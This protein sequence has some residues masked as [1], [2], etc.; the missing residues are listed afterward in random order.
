M[1]VFSLESL[2][3]SI[4]K[5]GFSQK[6]E[7]FYAFLIPKAFSFNKGGSL[8]P[9]LNHFALTPAYSRLA[10]HVFAIPP[11]PGGNMAALLAPK[12]PNF[13]IVALT[14]VRFAF[15]FVFLSAFVS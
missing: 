8:P 3:Y 1:R 13:F 12:P 14:K 11:S 4:F 5:G 15:F 7:F 9:R 2:Y 6:L 10:L